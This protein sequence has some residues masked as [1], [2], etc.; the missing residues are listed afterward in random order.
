MPRERKRL[1]MGTSTNVGK[2]MITPNSTLARLASKVLRPARLSIHSGRT[3]GRSTPTT[4]TPRMRSG[5]IWRTKRQVSHR[6]DC[7]S[8]AGRR[9]AVRQSAASSNRTIT[10]LPVNTTCSPPG[11]GTSCAAATSSVAATS[12][13]ATGLQRLGPS[14]MRPSPRQAVIEMS[15]S[16][17]MSRV[18]CTVTPSSPRVGSKGTSW[19][20]AACSA[21]APGKGKFSEA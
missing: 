9:C 12:A 11:T 20:K 2:Y 3:S 21:C 8:S 17:I 10:N 4:N 7:I 13:S 18:P 16:R 5:M 19:F 6:K 15:M 14:S 1:A